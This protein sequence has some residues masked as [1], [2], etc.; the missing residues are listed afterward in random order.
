[1]REPR[2]G[3]EAGFTVIEV[4]VA[5]MLVAVGTGAVLTAMT[6]PQKHTLTA[7]RQ[8]QAGLIAERTLETVVQRAQSNWANIAPDAAL[9]HQS[10]ANANNPSDPRF[11][12]SGTRFLIQQDYHDASRGLV[13]STPS[14]GEPLAGAIGGA[15]VP[16]TVRTSGTDPAGTIYT[17]VSY[18]D[19]SCAPTL[20][21]QIL[22][23]PLTAVGNLISGLLT[24]VGTL[25]N[26]LLG[27]NL[28]AGTG[29]VFCTARQDDKRVTVAVS[30]DKP[31]N[32]AAP[33]KPVYAS[34]LIPNPNAGILSGTTSS[35]VPFAPSCT[36]VA[37]LIQ[38]GQ[39]G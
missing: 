25:V 11:F 30:L 35:P 38:L 34:A 22:N 37:G 10:D 4:L 29:N 31:G 26:T 32:G 13:A 28:L 5:V 9:A 20:P 8:A 6:M 17:F 3:G 14:T 7:Q 33:L 21:G 39:C 1:M 15:G 12:I 24:A 27:N 23:G 18:H 16:A 19:E 2:R 36:I